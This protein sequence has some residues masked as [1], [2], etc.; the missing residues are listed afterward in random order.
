MMRLNKRSQARQSAEVQRGGS[1]GCDP[2]PHSPAAAITSLCSVCGKVR[3]GG[4]CSP[5]RLRLPAPAVLIMLEGPEFPRGAFPELPTG[6]PAPLEHLSTR[7]DPAH[8]KP[9]HFE[10]APAIRQDPSP[11]WRRFFFSKHHPCPRT[12]LPL[13]P[14]SPGPAAHPPLQN[15]CAEGQPGDS[16]LPRVAF[17][18]AQVLQPLPGG[19]ESSC[20]RRKGR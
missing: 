7:S 11:F 1:A 20:G 18:A 10:Q 15:P 16:E 9:G 4:R 17:C 12:L 8:I 3:P 5:E 19:K 14:R 13:A 6:S 2:A